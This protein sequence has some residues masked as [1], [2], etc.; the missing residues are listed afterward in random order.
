MSSI[1]LPLIDNGQ[2]DIK[3]NFHVCFLNAFAGRDVHT[4]RFSDSLI[5]RARNR[6]AAA[7]LRTNRDYLFFIDT[8]IIF[9]RDHLDCI[10]QSDEPLLC[11]LYCKKENEVSPCLNFLP[12]QP[13]IRVGGLVPI[14]RS[15]TGFMRIHRSLFEAMKEKDVTKSD[16]CW[17]CI[18]PYAPKYTNHGNQEWDFFGVGVRHREYLSE[19]WLFCDRARAL[20]FKVMLD[21]RVQTKHEGPTIFPTDEAVKRQA[22]REQRDGFDPPK[23]GILPQSFNGEVPHPQITLTPPTNRKCPDLSILV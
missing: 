10:M 6:A 2:G 11:G 13:P 22:E 8:D 3:A 20:G 15:G 17:C 4:E 21:S 23:P 1:F 18:W 12:D 19:D 7:F 5:P 16:A 9:S 14:A